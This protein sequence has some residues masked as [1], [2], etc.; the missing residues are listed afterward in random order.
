MIGAN[1][2]YVASVHLFL[3]HLEI[4][5][6]SD[7][8]PVSAMEKLTYLL[9]MCTIGYLLKKYIGN[10][11]INFAIRRVQQCF[12]NSKCYFWRELSE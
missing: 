6:K 12:G 10:I 11:L 7:V 3:K 5:A 2:F 1:Y 9:L 8:Y 4:L